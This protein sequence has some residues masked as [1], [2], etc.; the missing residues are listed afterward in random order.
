VGDNVG[1]FVESVQSP[2]PFSEIAPGLF[3]GQAMHDAFA[4]AKRAARSG[5]SI[6]VIGPTGTGKER[7]AR[8]IHL[9]SGR[10]G[11]FHAVN[12][13]AL[14][15]NLAE[16]ELFGYR[17]GAFTGAE[18][19]ALGHFRAADQGTLFLDEIGELP[20]S[21]QT[22]LLRVLEDKSVMPLGETEATPIDVRII[23]ATQNPLA[24]SVSAGQFREDLR[25]RLAGLT[26]QLPLLRDRLTDVPALFRHFM[27]QHSDGRPP[28]YDA[29]LV[30]C[31]CLYSWP[32][33]VRELEQLARRLLAVHGPEQH[34]LRR[35]MLPE[36]LLAR[37]PPEEETGQPAG[38]KIGGRRE[39]DVQQLAQALKR[40][41]GVVA[42]AAELVGFS[43]QRA[44]RLLDGTS[45]EQFAQQHAPSDVEHS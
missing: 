14:P 8:A 12:C 40:S 22:K 20:L 7:I 33:N 21:M 38:G 13:A 11:A 3:G 6:V 16:A 45:P 25:A 15:Q 37:L 44:Y 35:T 26:V 31:L 41:G 42:V 4:L 18:R 1:I 27:V 30:E 10:R 2:V 24:S 17:K 28:E 39:H 43:R 9:L 5:L 36:E 23:V 32:G 29:K 34:K 19:A